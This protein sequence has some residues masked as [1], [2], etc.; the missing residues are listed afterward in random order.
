MSAP[1]CVHLIS[2]DVVL[3]EGYWPGGH[4]ALCGEPID[5]SN[6]PSTRCPDECECEVTYC[7]GCL[8]AATERIGEPTV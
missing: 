5:T 8:H 4:L 3:A 7:P 6:L 1:R 2:A